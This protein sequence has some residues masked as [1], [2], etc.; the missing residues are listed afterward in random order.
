MCKCT[1]QWQS[2][3]LTLANCYFLTG[4]MFF[5]LFLTQSLIN[6]PSVK[7]L[8]C[9]ATSSYQHCEAKTASSCFTFSAWSLPRVLTL[10][11]SYITTVS[12]QIRRT[13]V[14]RF[15]GRNIVISISPGSGGPQHQLSS[16]YLQWPCQKLAGKGH[17][18]GHTARP[19]Y[20]VVLPP[21]GEKRNYILNPQELLILFNSTGEP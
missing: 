21:W 17:S 19:S 14:F 2:A 7:D 4:Q 8:P 5:P 15:S 1:I 20:R 6:S 18:M 9:S 10:T 16:F 11:S 12:W 13:Q 3:R